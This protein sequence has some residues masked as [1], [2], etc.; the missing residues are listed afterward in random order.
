V[1]AFNEKQLKLIYQQLDPNKQAQL[2]LLIEDGLLF[3]ALENVQGD[4][5]KHLIISLGYGYNEAGK[6]EMRFGPVN[7]EGGGKRLNVLFSRGQDK[8]TFIH[9]VDAADFKITDNNGVDL[10]RKFM[11]FVSTLPPTETTL[12]FTVQAKQSKIN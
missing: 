10:L 8:L 4:E 7:Q 5:C 2:D 9:S 12:N 6:F 11:Q 1:V 3:K